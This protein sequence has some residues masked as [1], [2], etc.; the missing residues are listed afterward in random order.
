[1]LSQFLF[2]RSLSPP[3]VHVFHQH[4]PVLHFRP[5]PAHIIVSTLRPPRPPSSLQCLPEL[6]II[7]IDLSPSLE[8]S[9]LN[10]ALQACSALTRRSL[11][12]LQPCVYH[13]ERYERDS[14]QAGVVL[15]ISR[16]RGAIYKPQTSPKKWEQSMMNMQSAFWWSKAT[17]V[18]H[19]RP[20]PK[21]F[22]ACSLKTMA[23]C[24]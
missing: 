17:R 2:S 1:M 6:L 13:V 12:S 24:A 18:S 19:P 3:Q 23:F 14:V 10:C 16:A 4:V 9:L 8:Y 15:C 21:P 20:G 5:D 7:R 22:W 11:S